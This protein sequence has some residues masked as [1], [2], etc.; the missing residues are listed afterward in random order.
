VAREEEFRNGSSLEVVLD[1]FL[2]AAQKVKAAREVLY[3][4]LPPS[5]PGAIRR[6]LNSIYIQIPVV[7][8]AAE[9]F[10]WMIDD[11][12]PWPAASRTLRTREAK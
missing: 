10:E 3:G 6:A 8:T 4:G 7:L 9:T 12:I 2:E 1:E 5:D 11:L